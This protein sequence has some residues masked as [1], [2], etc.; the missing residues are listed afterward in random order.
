[1]NLDPALRAKVDDVRRRLVQAWPQSD[2]LVKWVAPENLHLTLKFLGGVEEGKAAQV[3]AAL[4][5]L[6]RMGAFYVRYVGLG[7]FPKPRGARVLWIGVAEGA[8]RLTALAAWVEDHL[9][10]L[11]FPP[12]D[13]PFSP[14]LTIGR[15]RTPAYHPELERIIQ[16]EARVEIGSQYVQSVEVMESVLRPQG[17]IYSVRAS[18]RLGVGDG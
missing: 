16:Q 1:M 14:H 8:D 5:G 13:R 12:E 10:P 2:R 4:E 11:G 3:L 9:R 7:A 6:A 17:P 15:L 18:Y